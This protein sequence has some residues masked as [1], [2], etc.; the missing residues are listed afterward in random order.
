MS[1]GER[2]ESL[3]EKGVSLG[4]KGVSLG[5]ELRSLSL[6]VPPE[7]TSLGGCESWSKDRGELT[8]VEKGEH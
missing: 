1:L 5:E 3:E 7:L 6:L 2:G 8:C 4:E